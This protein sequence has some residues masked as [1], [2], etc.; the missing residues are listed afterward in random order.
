MIAVVTKV[1]S[2]QEEI[3][4]R[5]FCGGEAEKPPP[6]SYVWFQGVACK[7]SP[8]S[9]PHG[10]RLLGVRG[11]ELCLEESQRGPWLCSHC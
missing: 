6:N 3:T 5:F 2:Y 10:N 8:G 4:K 9:L 7:G 1:S 11:G